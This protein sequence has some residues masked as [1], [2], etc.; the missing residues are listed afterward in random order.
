MKDK[1]KDGEEKKLE[2]EDEEALLSVA[3]TLRIWMTRCYI[4]TSSLQEKIPDLKKELPRLKALY[5]KAI[6]TS[7]IEKEVAEEFVLTIN[8]TFVSGI[9]KDLLIQSKDIYS[10]LLK[11]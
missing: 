4:K 10:Q 3:E 1:K 6:S 9:L 7:V 11:Q 8:K 2:T 5:E